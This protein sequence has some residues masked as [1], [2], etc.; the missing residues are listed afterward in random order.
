MTA[1][2]LSTAQANIKIALW[3]VEA[4]SITSDELYVWLVDSGLPY[5]VTIRLHEIVTYT[6]KIAGKVFAIGKIVL[7]KIIEF[8]KAHPFLVTGL[9]IGAVVGAA[10][11][12]LITSIPILGQLLAPVAAGLGIAITIT[13]A[14]IGHRM[15]KRF[16][17]VGD[18][19]YEIAREFFKL[20]VDIINVFLGK[21]ITA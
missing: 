9:S 21:V 2:A 11:A 15:D 10:V 8:V 1:K 17:G 7:I 14:V 3:Q 16:S 13:G 12:A 18:D 4:D 5:E 20:F 19:I 6:K